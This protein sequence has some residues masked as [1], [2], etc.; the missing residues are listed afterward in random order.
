MLVRVKPRQQLL[1]TAN[2]EAE[3]WARA[4]EVFG[5]VI[6]GALRV[7]VGATFPLRAAAEAHRALEGR[8]TTGKV[9]LVP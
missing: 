9:L 2:Q 3:V 7:H 8:A 4:A 1:L 6:N 5:W